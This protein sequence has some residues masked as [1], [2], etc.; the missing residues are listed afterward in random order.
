MMVGAGADIT[1]VAAATLIT[2]FF[3]R[4]AIDALPTRADS[5]PEPVSNATLVPPRS[6]QQVLKR[7]Q[8]RQRSHGASS[9]GVKATNEGIQTLLGRKAYGERRGSVTSF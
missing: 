4:L 2:T 5:A 1:A 6:A 3:G 8:R 9:D 7:R